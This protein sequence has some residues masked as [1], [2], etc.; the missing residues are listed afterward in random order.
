MQAK[1][2]PLLPL[3]IFGA[4]ALAAGLLALLFPETMGKSLPDSVHESKNLKDV[5]RCHSNGKSMQVPK[6][7]LTPSSDDNRI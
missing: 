4:S 5:E 1:I 2:S 6:V 3:E 7:V